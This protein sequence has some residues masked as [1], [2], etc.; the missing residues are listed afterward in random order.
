VSVRFRRYRWVFYIQV[1]KLIRRTFLDVW[2][3]P[4][5]DYIA[6]VSRCRHAA[7]HNTSVYEG[8]Y[9]T[10]SYV[11]FTVSECIVLCSMRVLDA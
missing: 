3:G 10:L 1:S 11:N 7:A 5:V 6:Y 9:D 8:T 2:S 4:T